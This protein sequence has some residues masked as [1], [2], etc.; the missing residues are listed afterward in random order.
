M[1]RPA[2]VLAAVPACVRAVAL[3][4][5]QEV[6]AAVVAWAPAAW[7]AAQRVAAWAALVRR[8]PVALQVSQVPVAAQVAQVLAL[9]DKAGRALRVP[10][11]WVAAQGKA[12]KVARTRNT[13][14][15][16]S[17]PL[18]SSS[19]TIAWSRRR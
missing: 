3:E 1:A 18:T 17:C 4:A 6:A 15:T 2:G 13:S 14:R 19:T 12:A 16:T 11:A 10:V 7:A 8:L 9:P 5:A